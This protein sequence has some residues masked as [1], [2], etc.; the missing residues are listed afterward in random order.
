MPAD[1]TY[2]DKFFA[3]DTNRPQLQ[4]MMSNLIES[5]IVN[6]HGFDRV[7]RNTKDILSMVET[8]KENGCDFKIA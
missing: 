7:G 3:K 4:L 5:D 8:I 1:R 6:G 2:E